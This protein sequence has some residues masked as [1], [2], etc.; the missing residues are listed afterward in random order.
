MKFARW[1]GIIVQALVLGGLLCL[2]IGKMVA[3]A[4]GARVFEYQG[5]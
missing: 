5:F 2:A 4:T 3:V 1:T